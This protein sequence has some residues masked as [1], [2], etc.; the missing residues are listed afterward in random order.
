MRAVDLIPG[1]R[2][3]RLEPD[4]A[5]ELS[6]IELEIF[7]SPWSENALR[8]CL[9]LASVEG[10]AAV[11]KDQIVAYLFAQFAFDEAHIMNLGVR[12]K[13]RRKGI[14]QTLL[15]RFL[16]RQAR[17]GTKTC[18][19][20]VRLSN[21]IAQKLYYDHGFAPLSLRKKYYPNGEDALILIK[22]F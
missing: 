9:E 14:A 22:R 16:D 1:L 12:P 2:F 5:R 21:R 3:R 10:E 18:Y 19:L 6:Y 13:Y 11:I 17:R 8:S 7:P 15:K 20:E 4:D